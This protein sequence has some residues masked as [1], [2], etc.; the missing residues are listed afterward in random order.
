MVRLKD[1]A[2]RAGVS[3]MTVS[4]VM[5]DAPDISKATK[6][7]VRAMADE[8]GY[9][10]N[11]AARGL[12]SRSSKLL[13]LLIPTTTNPIYARMILAIESRAQE[14]G[15]DLLI[16]HTLND[17]GR[18]EY[19]IKRFIARRIDGLLLNPVYRLQ[20]EASIYRELKRHSIPTVLLSHPAEFCE[21]FPYVAVDDFQAGHQAASHLIELG[22]SKIGFIAGPTLSPG[23]RERAEG[24]RKALNDNRLEFDDQRMFQA[25]NTIE[26]GRTVGTEIAN[27]RPDCTAFQAA[28]DL[29]AIG[30]AGVLMDQGLQI[31][32]DFSLIG[33]GNVL[34]AEHFRVPLTTIRQPKFRLGIAG[35]E[36][37]S[38]LLE[39]ETPPNQ[40]IPAELFVRK[41]TAPPLTS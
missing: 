39:G 31:P 16:G 18:E 27:E 33:H 38:R 21:D 3:V 25:G 11:T 36:I 10:P 7:R 40:R 32:R 35:I 34:T 30:A 1:I 20:K 41:S 4:K 15:Y 37:L 5:R 22:H 26:E 8:M 28:N 24:F 29:A 6:A 9:V 2:Q 23:A 19:H 17:P 13:G 12:R 14:M